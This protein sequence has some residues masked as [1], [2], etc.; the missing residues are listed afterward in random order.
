MFREEAGRLNFNVENFRAYARTLA[1]L[2][3]ANENVC[4]ND[5]ISL[6]LS[7]FSQLVSQSTQ[8][9]FIACLNA[10]VFSS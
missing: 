10:T 2:I 3:A 6:Y 9:Y 7:D 4:I 8:R 5:S 1:L